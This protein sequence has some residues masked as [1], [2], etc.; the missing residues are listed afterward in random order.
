MANMETQIMI[1]LGIVLNRPE[2]RS[3]EVL[4]PWTVV[5]GGLGML[6]QSFFAI[7]LAGFSSRLPAGL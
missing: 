2:F 4:V 1:H 3:G 7:A 5:I 6:L